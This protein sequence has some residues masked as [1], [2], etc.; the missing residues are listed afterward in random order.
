MLCDR[1]DPLVWQT[2]FDGTGCAALAESAVTLTHHDLPNGASFSCQQE[3]RERE[4]NAYT[5]AHT[6]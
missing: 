6:L 4:H 3:E 1:P 5:R 2:N